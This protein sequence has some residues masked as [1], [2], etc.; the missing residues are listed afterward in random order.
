MNDR[1][2]FM[3][4]M[5]FGTPDRIPYWDFGMLPGT[6]E[7]WHS[8]GMPTDGIIGDL[9]ELD[10][11]RKIDV[12]FTMVPKFEIETLSEDAEYQVFRD[13]FGIMQRR[14]KANL[15]GMPEFLQYPIA[16][17][18]D[19]Q[20][21][22]E[23]YDPSSSERYPPDWSSYVAQNG[24]DRTFT[25]YLQ[26]FRHVGFFGP[27]R[28]WM[29]LETLLMAMV[30]QP[31]WVEEMTEFVADTIIGIRQRI[32]AKITLD[33]VTFFEDIG[34]KTS[35]LIS[36]AMF[37]RFMTGPYR[38]VTDCFRSCGTQC[39]FADSDG[40][41]DNLIPLWME[42]GVN[43]FSPMEAQ[44]EG[45]GPVELRA[46]YPDLLLYGGM[47]KRALAR[48]R[49]AVYDDVMMKV[50]AMIESGGFIPTMDHQ[51]PPDASFENYCYYWDLLKAVAQGRSQPDPAGWNLRD[52][53]QA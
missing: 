27:L 32:P 17:R 45:S 21:M 14:Q 8:E 48:D 24:D 16:N 52:Y 18:G 12:D 51:V 42:A 26:E 47:D 1:Q 44:A 5:T 28:N 25:L 53:L 4:T 23:R 39:F 37:R 2:R 43:G 36:P 7:R 46:R 15:P 9:F 41:N 11:R 6:L 3:A 35:T 10:D 49:Q 30:E 20:K 22:K 50:P 33:Y 38:R 40:Y 19:F 29:G 13:Q 31:A 34:Y